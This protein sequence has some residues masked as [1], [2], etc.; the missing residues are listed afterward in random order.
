MPGGNS[1]TSSDM[2]ANVRTPPTTT[3]ATEKLSPTRYSWPATAAATTSA[4][5]SKRPKAAA[6]MPASGSPES[7]QICRAASTSGASS[8]VIAKKHHWY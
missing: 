4:P 8:S 5:F 2:R 6:T 1:G 7:F 3:S